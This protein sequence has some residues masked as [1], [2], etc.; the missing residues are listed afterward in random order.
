MFADTLTARE[1]ATRAIFHALES[2][3]LLEKALMKATRDLETEGLPEL[4][5]SLVNL[6]EKMEAMNMGEAVAVAIDEE[7]MEA[8]LGE[9][10]PEFDNPW[11]VLD[12][13]CWWGVH[14]ELRDVTD[15]L[16]SEVGQRVGDRLGASR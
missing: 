15:L 16:L 11:V 5:M 12:A 13:G 9:H 1:A 10:F 14:K 7:S 2:R 8:L 6:D 3:L 4:A